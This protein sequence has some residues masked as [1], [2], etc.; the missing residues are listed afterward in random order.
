MAK[1]YYRARDRQGLIVEGATRATNPYFARK[2]LNNENL[3]V[4]KLSRF[5]LKIFSQELNKLFENFFEKVT[6]DEQMVLMSQ[7]EIGISV[8][9]P[10][11]KMFDLLQKD[12]KNKYLKNAII[13]VAQ[14]VTEGS[15]LHEAFAKHPAIFDSTMVGLIKTGEVSGK[16]EATLSRIT[17]MIAQQSENRAK[18]KSAIFYPKI[19]LFV[20]AT[21]LLSVV[22]FIIPK[23]KTLL[24]SLG[25]DLPPITKIVVAT[26]DF[27]VSYWYLVVAIGFVAFALYKRA[28]TSEKGKRRLD[29]I[30]LRIPV[31]GTLF[32]YLE[33]NNLCVILDLLIGSGIP[34]YDA[35]GTLKDTQK[36]E[37]FREELTRLQ[38]ELSQGGSL[39]SGLES[40]E[41]F[42][43]TFKSLLSMGEESGQ[44]ELVLRRLAK[45]YQVEIDYRLDNLSK[46]IE[47]ILLFIIFGMVLVLALAIL[48]PIWKMNSAIMGAH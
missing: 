8:G 32:T 48:L 5:N 35:L 18:I 30:K 25:T 14:T 45:H 23:L 10:I 28:V 15:T 16:I 7:I 33:M 47:P 6:L 42:P 37:L 46:L 29:Q 1:Y 24:A 12:I 21:V 4:L 9:I 17:S 22:Y 39:S 27:F 44:M 26:S 3:I 34:L 19:V 11:V 38:A 41:I 20:L 2:A 43:S 13:D 40:S 31:F 36:N